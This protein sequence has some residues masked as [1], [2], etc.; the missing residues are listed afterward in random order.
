MVPICAWQIKGG[1]GVGQVGVDA[2]ATLA[3]VQPFLPPTMF[4]GDVEGG[5]G[6]VVSSD[7]DRTMGSLTEPPRVAIGG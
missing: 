6:G 3:K 4:Q 5:G 2:V 1:V 7:K